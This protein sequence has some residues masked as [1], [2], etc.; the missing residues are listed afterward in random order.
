LTI[1]Y[2][3]QYLEFLGLAILMAGLGFILLKKDQAIDKEKSR[4][5]NYPA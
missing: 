2:W 3:P 4:Q 1:V 5:Y